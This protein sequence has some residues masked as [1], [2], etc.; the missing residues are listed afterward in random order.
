M[1]NAQQGSENGNSRVISVF[2]FPPSLSNRHQE[3]FKKRGVSP[4][5]AL[6][7][8][9][10]TAADNELRDLNFQ[11][12]LPIDER[13]KG[14]QGICFPYRDI[15]CN[16]EAAWR[17]KPDVQFNLSDGSHPKYLSR[18]G[19]K[20][21]AY[22]PHTTTKELISD[23]KVN[24]VITEGEYKTLAIAEALQKAESKRK[25]AVVGLQGVNGGWHREKQTVPTADGGHEKKSVG[26]PKLIDDLQEIEWKKRT[27]YIIFDSDIA[28]K[29]HASAFKQSKYAGAWG[30]ERTLADLLKAQGAEVRIVEI[31]DNLTGEKVGA[32]DYIAKHGHYEFLKLMWNNWT[33]ERNVDEV[34][35]QEDS[36]ALVFV[37]ARELV[38]IKPPR[39][40]F[41]IDKLLPEGGTMIIAASP[42][43]GKSGIA[44]NAAKSIATGEA[45]LG[46]FPVRK[47]RCVYV[48]TE[49]PAWA[50]AERLKLMG[51][52]P[53]GM[54]IHTP[55]KF[56][57]NLWEED[58]YQKKRETGNRERVAAL[59][60][61]L[62]AQ[63][64]SLVIFDP[65]RH[66]HSLNELNVDHVAHLFEVFRTIGRMVPCGV[67]IV[68]HHRKTARSQVE[69]EG[70]EDMSG[71]GALFGEA[72]SIV[73]IYKKVR[74]GD[75]TRRYKMVFD[76][77]HAETPDP[78]E[79][80]RMGGD[81]AMLWSAEPWA[82]I[83]SGTADE[84]IE[85]ILSVIKPNGRY[86][87]KEIEELSGVKHTK[88]YTGLK[89]LAASGQIIKDGNVYY[90]SFES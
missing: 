27:V 6:A 90:A 9:C 84:S 33:P 37:E 80:F 43:V 48:Q 72:D 76:L 87:A 16:A 29:K 35:Y 63:A 23:P 3:E 71:S 86:R 83:P 50:M 57:I 49:I 38:K 89:Q 24:M 45:F 8:G 7:S 58:G 11:A 85:R 42:K 82:D 67:M 28:S 65:L 56:K 15:E 32:D 75:D 1:E 78:M 47:G 13:K 31:P 22:F 64:A 12:S 79:L 60:E 68:H 44:L 88:L 59:I 39:P 69:Y 25:F 36:K 10:R 4:E 61:A 30:A 81:N 18:I 62:R 14:L 74:L 54:L 21:R 40:V 5:F 53:E 46:A 52:L 66:F 2:K 26:A 41:V 55:G 77:R 19:D 34:L 51:D 70:A 20:V 17:I 73:S